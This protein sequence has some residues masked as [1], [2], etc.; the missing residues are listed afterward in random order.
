MPKSLLC[1]FIIGL[2]LPACQEKK[3]TPAVDT[4]LSE[5]VDEQPPTDTSPD[6]LGST[7]SA[8][9][10]RC[11]GDDRRSA[12]QPDGS[13]AVENCKSGELC[14]AGECAPVVCEP[15]SVSSC[16]QD[17][18]YRG[19]N[20][21]G[22]GEGEHDCPSGMSC[23]GEACVDRVCDEGQTICL[24]DDT[25]GVCAPNGSAYLPS[26]RCSDVDVKKTCDEGQCKPL[27]EV[28]L[29]SPSYVGCEYWAVDLDNAI[30]GPYNAAGQ[31]FAVVLSNTSETLVAEVLAYDREGFEAS[32]Q[33]PLYRLSV[34]PNELRVLVLPPDCY[35]GL[36]CQE[37]FAVNNTTITPAAYFIRSDVPIT[38]YQFNPL[39][40]V[41]VFSNDASLLFPTLA[42]G[43][44]YYVMTRA[45]Q[46]FSL[47]GF[48]TVV[49]GGDGETEVEIR[50]AAA[51][52]EGRIAETG[53]RIPPMQ[54]WDSRTFILEPFDVL[55][56]STDAIGADLTGSLVV[57]NKPVAVFGGSEA[58][59]APETT[60]VTCCADH[61]EQQMYPVNAW[62]LHYHAA[63][64]YARKG[65]RD[66]WRIMARLPNTTVYTVPD[67]SDGPRVLQEGE[68]FE[69]LNTEDFE[70]HA[71]RPILVGQFLAS[72]WDPIDPNTGAPSP[73]AAGTGDPSFIL[74]APSEQYRRQYVFLVPD[75]YEH[76]YISVIA[77]S[78][79]A[80]LLDG[81]PIPAELF[82]PFGATQF[83]AARL[84]IADGVHRIEASEPV[85]L[86]VYGY[87]SYV[88]YGYPAGL[89][90]RSLFD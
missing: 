58:A 75:K 65:E 33:A 14:Y 62:G 34:P 35:G 11:L 69:L 15:Y 40:N 1:A 87:D 56:L 49:A 51:T 22:T 17:G 3:V 66:L 76:D 29:K 24:D 60:P 73:Q 18:R 54:K 50:V 71:D 86:Y 28:S 59:N 9:Q 68:F 82:T 47:R 89:D 78:Q 43:R 23:I 84:P 10:N 8:A 79:S 63:K 85:G 2:A 57:A 27:C 12:C 26:T 4:E 32:P 52:M 44:R 38:A 61:L 53:E 19:C 70:L 46:H 81:S 48:L 30:D 90:L 20:P 36:T 83:S 67:V 13:F 55:N 64:S 6:E 80:V 42:W 74:L 45:Q 72:E 16:L 7:C 88:S 37:A 5:S 39:D 41:D 31:P 25:V 21:M 77:P